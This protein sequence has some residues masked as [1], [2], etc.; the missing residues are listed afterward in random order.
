MRTAERVYQFIWRYLTAN[1][2]LP[3]YPQIADGL[4]VTKD[5]VSRC[6]RLLRAQERLCATTLKPTAYDAWWCENVRREQRWTVKP[7]IPLRR[8]QEKQLPLPFR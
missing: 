5:E 2:E 7:L 4:H 8:L 3:G 6:I 1:E